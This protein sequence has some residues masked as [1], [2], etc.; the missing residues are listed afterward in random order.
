MTTLQGK[1]LALALKFAVSYLRKHPELLDEV[2]KHI[3]GKVDDLALKV[4]AKLLGV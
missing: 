1:L 4:L 3:P 2:S